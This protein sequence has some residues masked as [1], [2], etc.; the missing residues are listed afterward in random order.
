MDDT[1]WIAPN[2]IQLQKILDTAIQF[3]DINDIHINPEKSQL[4]IINGKPMDFNNGVSMDNTF[5]PGCKKGTPVQIL[6]V[7]HDSAGNKKFQ[8]QLI[9]NKILLT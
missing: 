7:W 2:Q 1:T 4:L 6:G 5:I 3:Y 9:H 8:K